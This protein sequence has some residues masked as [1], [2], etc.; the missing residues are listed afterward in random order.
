VGVLSVERQPVV[1]NQPRFSGLRLKNTVPHL[2]AY[3]LKS[4]AQRLLPFGFLI[5]EAAKEQFCI[6]DS[7]K[8]LPSALDLWMTMLHN[9]EVF[10][11]TDADDQVI[12]IQALL[13]VVPARSAQWLAYA[14]PDKRGSRRILKA[15]MELMD[16]AFAPFPE[17][18]GLLKVTAKVA[19]ENEPVL[20]MMHK[21][22]GAPVGTLR[23]DGLFQGM[24]CDMVVFE[25]YHPDLYAPQGEP[26]NVITNRGERIQP[27]CEPGGAAGGRP[28][29]A[30]DESA[31]VPTADDDH[32]RDNDTARENS[33]AIDS[34]DDG[35]RERV[36]A[37]PA[38]NKRQSVSK[39]RRKG[40]V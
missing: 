28:D 11:C 22:G 14:L 16:Y 4:V 25:F 8:K 7:Y 40:K 19:I 20:R 2:R 13:S 30:L 35:G 34:G 37:R 12:G 32:R 1:V 38:R 3:E 21:L 24:L 18:L 26:I 33:A 5:T 23:C 6:D 9:G 31:D 29:E 17:G 10:I 27:L 15:A 39:P 36:A